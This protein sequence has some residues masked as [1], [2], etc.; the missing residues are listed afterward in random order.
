MACTY[1]EV[2]AEFGW[3][4]DQAKL[5]GMRTAN[6]AKLQQLEENIKDADE[7][8]GDTEVRRFGYDAAAHLPRIMLRRRQS[9]GGGAVLTCGVD[10]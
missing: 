3:P 5:S 10:V 2:C 6:A 8:L 7:N 9:A 4:L 1:E